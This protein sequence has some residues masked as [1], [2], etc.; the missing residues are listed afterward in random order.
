MSLYN[1]LTSNSDPHSRHSEWLDFIR[2]R[3]WTR[4][5]YEEEMVPSYD[6]LS[7]HWK[8]S[9]WVSSVWRQATSNVIVYP[10]LENFGWKQPD[11]QTL[12]I[13]WDSDSNISQIKERVAFI[14]KG[15]SCKTGCST[16]RCKCKKNGSKCGPNAQAV[17]TCR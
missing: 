12:N 2:N 17:L 4:I 15:C 6:A 10:P 11:Q 9:C 14:R 16:G 3:I 8:R 13:D 1:S 7:R 5:Q